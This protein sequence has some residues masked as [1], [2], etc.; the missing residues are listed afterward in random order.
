LQGQ[1][2]PFVLAVE[3]GY[4]ARAGVDVQVDRGF[5]SADAITKVASGAYD[6]AFADISTMIQFAGRQGPDKVVSVFQVFD[7][8]P[9]VMLSL[10]K[11]NI[12]KPLDLAGKR[13]AAPPGSSSRMMFPLLAAAGGLD[14]AT[15]KWIDVT[16]QLRETLL[17]QGQADATTAL[18]TDIPGLHHLGVT[19]ADLDVMR[20]ADFG[21]T[22][23][24]HCILTTPQFAARNPDAVR[25]VVAG[26]AQALKAAIADPAAS[27]AALHKRNPLQDDAVEQARLELVIRNAIVT[28]AVRRDGLGTV[29]PARLR[30]TID[31]VARVFSVPAPDPAAVYR[32]DFLPARA[33]L[34]LRN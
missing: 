7:V 14:L 31:L 1:Q 28:D 26:F 4:F 16:P 9:L 32:A 34:A 2:S 33:A 3:G 12:H 11:A 8:A 18:V 30:Q 20:F 6:M 29:D 10:K 15:I 25:A 21:V 27:I 13:V 24:G 22:V 19:D 17:M 5:G 23:Y